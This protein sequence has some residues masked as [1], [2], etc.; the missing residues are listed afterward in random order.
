MEY[1]EA[2]ELLIKSKPLRKAFFSESFFDFCQFY[3]KEY[4]SFDTPQC[5]IEYYNALES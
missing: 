4:Y 3:F 5:L 1:N 2:V